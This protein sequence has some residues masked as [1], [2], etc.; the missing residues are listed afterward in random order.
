[1]QLGVLTL[2]EFVR[3][4]HVA[5]NFGTGGAAMPGTHASRR[6][7]PHQVIWYLIAGFMMFN[8]NWT[9]LWTLS[10]LAL[11]KSRAGL[12][13]D[14]ATQKLDHFRLLVGASANNS[15]AWRLACLMVPV[16]AA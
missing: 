5:L 8:S 2:V 1:M 14:F 3:L 13:L 15:T 10:H 4:S 12:R 11:H 9:S 16:L 6:E 7:G